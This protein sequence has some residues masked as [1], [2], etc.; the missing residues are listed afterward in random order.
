[1]NGLKKLHDLKKMSQRHLCL[2][3]SPV[4]SAMKAMIISFLVISSLGSN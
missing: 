4:D 2:C 1:M 3:F